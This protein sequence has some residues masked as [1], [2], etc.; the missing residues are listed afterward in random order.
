MVDT[1]YRHVAI[2]IDLYQA[3]LLLLDVTPLQRSMADRPTGHWS[4][5]RVDAEQFLHLQHYYKAVLS[6]LE[7]QDEILI[8][9]PDQAKS[10]LL[11]RIEA[12]QGERGKVVG[13]HDAFRLSGVDLVYPTGEEWRAEDED[14]RRAVALTSKS[15]SET[16][17]TLGRLP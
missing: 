11:R 1:T 7:P 17:G 12:C 3:V 8:L 10:E 5:L 2:W 6:L 14:G 15:A 13:I 4:Q 9:G 16:G